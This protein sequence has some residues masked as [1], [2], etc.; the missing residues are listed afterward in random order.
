[1]AATTTEDVWL[2]LRALAGLASLPVATQDIRDEGGTLLGALASA[3]PDGGA[4]LLAMPDW[5]VLVPQ[6]APAP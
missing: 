3:L 5:A 1:V 6:A 2:R 4:A